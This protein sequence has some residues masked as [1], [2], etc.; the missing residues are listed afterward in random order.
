MR[1]YDKSDLWCV[2]LGTEGDHVDLV[3]ILPRAWI[4]PDMLKLL[5]EIDGEAS[6][7]YA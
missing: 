3:S 2:R 4:A 1:F 6:R 7:P 5:G